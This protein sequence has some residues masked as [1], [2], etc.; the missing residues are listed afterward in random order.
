MYMK[1]G[2]IFRERQKNRNE[3]SP[4]HAPRKRTKE[5]QKRKNVIWDNILCATWE[6]ENESENYVIANTSPLSTRRAK[7]MLNERKVGSD[8][9]N[10]VILGSR[11]TGATARDDCTTCKSWVRRT[12]N[13]FCR[14]S[15]AT[16]SSYDSW[17]NDEEVADAARGTSGGGDGVNGMEEIEECSTRLCFFITFSR[18]WV[19]EVDRH[20]V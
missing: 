2:D 13:C 20:A 6:R 17:G 7:R 10:H 15:C 3:S 8:H 1:N 11:A 19:R 14:F 12:A 16:R 4:I 5:K 18:W 9:N